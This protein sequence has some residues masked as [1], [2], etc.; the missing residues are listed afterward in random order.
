[1]SAK[2]PECFQV[3]NSMY[4]TDY[5][6]VQ[7]LKQI[8]TERNPTSLQDTTELDGYFQKFIGLALNET[9]IARQFGCKTSKDANLLRYLPSSYLALIVID[10][11]SKKCTNAN[12]LPRLCKNV[13][14]AA[15]KSLNNFVNLN[16]CNISKSEFLALNQ[17]FKEISNN[18]S[19]TDQNGCLTGFGQEPKQCGM[20][21][22]SL[23]I[24][25]F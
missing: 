15:E 16:E 4:F 3:Q 17:A 14:E 7:I 9:Q 25:D 12:P 18:N 23:I 6:N 20:L 2:A 1:M 11:T 13:V 10:P 5:N 24:Q 22:I 19:Y 8:P 21:L